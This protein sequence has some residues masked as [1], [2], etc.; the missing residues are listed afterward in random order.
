MTFFITDV[1]IAFAKLSGWAIVLHTVKYNNKNGWRLNWK[2]FCRDEMTIVLIIST[3]RFY[4]IS[5]GRLKLWSLSENPGFSLWFHDLE[6]ESCR[7]EL[8]TLLKSFDQFSFQLTPMTKK[9]LML[10]PVSQL[11][12][13]SKVNLILII[14]LTHKILSK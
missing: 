7:A 13:H 11:F 3:C 1:L 6:N 2:F 12:W 14:S 9:I 8:V 5:W 10:H 4:N